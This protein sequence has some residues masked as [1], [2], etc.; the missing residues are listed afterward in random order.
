MS[1]NTSVNIESKGELTTLL[2]GNT[3]TYRFEN[4]DPKNPVVA[5]LSVQG[6]NAVDAMTT[7]PNAKLRI[8]M[9]PDDG[10]LPLDAQ[11]LLAKAEGVANWAEALLDLVEGTDCNPEDEE[12]FNE[13]LMATGMF[14]KSYRDFVKK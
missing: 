6:D 3:H 12:E 8:S 7:I 1:K 13:V 11:Q 5:V 2:G 10:E 9:C 4:A 14:L